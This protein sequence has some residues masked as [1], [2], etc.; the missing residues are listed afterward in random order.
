MS[1][2]ASCA[3]AAPV[4]A[5]RDMEIVRRLS[6]GWRHIGHLWLDV[7]I[8]IAQSWQGEGQLGGQMEERE[9]SGAPCTHKDDGTV[10]Q[11]C[12]AAPTCR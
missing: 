3:A 12:R 4:I 8:S 11:W 7:C 10:G 5:S 9:R 1:N 6:T 2:R